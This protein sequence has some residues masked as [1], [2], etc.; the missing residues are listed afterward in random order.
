MCGEPG[1]VGRKTVNN[2]V[3]M[4]GESGS[5]RRVFDTHKLPKSHARIMF[6]RYFTLRGRSIKNGYGCD[7]RTE[8]PLSMLVLFSRYTLV[9]IIHFQPNEIAVRL[10]YRRYARF[11]GSRLKIMFRRSAIRIFKVR[12]MR[13]R[14]SRVDQR[15]S[16][17]LFTI[18]RGHIPY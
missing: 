12:M 18:C 11:G 2:C 1:K 10:R 7:N 9:F 13:R 15:R 16:E 8:Y 6:T 17:S 14:S 5:K 3:W 4:R